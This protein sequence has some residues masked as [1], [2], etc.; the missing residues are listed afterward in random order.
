MPGPAWQAGFVQACTEKLAADFD[1]T[2][3]TVYRYGLV[4]HASVRK[5]L[6]AHFMVL[7]G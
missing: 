1:A 7:G 6:V 3:T 5:I 2:V 4:V